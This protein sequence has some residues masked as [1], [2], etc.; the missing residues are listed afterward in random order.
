[1]VAMRDDNRYRAVSEALVFVS[2]SHEDRAFVP[3]LNQYLKPLLPSGVTLWW[4]NAIRVG[5]RFDDVIRERI[6]QS[7]AAVVLVSPALAASDFITN[8]EL[9]ALIERGIPLAPLH[10][11]AP[12]F[13][14]VPGLRDV[15]WVQP[16]VGRDEPI[17]L[18][19]D[20]ESSQAQIDQM[21]VRLSERIASRI[22]AEYETW[23]AAHGPDHEGPVGERAATPKAEIVAGSAGQLHGVPAL[24]DDIVDR[25]DELSEL[26]TLLLSLAPALGLTGT[27]TMG[28]QGQGGIGK[29]VLATALARDPQVLAAFP[30]GI[31]WV[32]LGEGT[33][34]GL[35]QQ[36]LLSL[37]D[38]TATPQN[39]WEIRQRLVEVLADKQTLLMV[40]DIWT[41]QAGR[42]FQL[43]G[44]R[45][46]V[47]YT[48][49]DERVLDDVG[50][51]IS[52]VDVLSGDAAWA[53]LQRSSRWADPERPAAWGRVAAATG[54]VALGLALAGAALRGAPAEKWSD[55]VAELESDVSWLDHP[56][57]DVF[58]VMNLATSQ[59]PGSHKQRLFSLAVYPE[60]IQIP[61]ESITT[62]WGHMFHDESKDVLALV[63]RL[64]AAELIERS[65]GHVR[66]HD[67]RREFLRLRADDIVVLH[68]RLIEA[69]RARGGDWA[70]IAEG[71]P[72]LADHLIAHLISALDQRQAEAVLRD[73]A[74]VGLRLVSKGPIA[75]DGDLRH[76]APSDTSRQLTETV[77]AEIG[78]WAHLVTSSPD[79]RLP[80]F[81]PERRSTVL[82]QMAPT[83]PLDAA[84][85]RRSVRPGIKPQWHLRAAHP[86]QRL[87]LDGHTGGVWGVAWSPDGTR[88]A[89]ASADKTVR[90]WDPATGTQTQQLDGHTDSVRGVA[91]SPDSTRLASASADKTV[92]IWPARVA[93]GWLRR[94]GP[95]R[96]LL[97][98]PHQSVNAGGVTDVSFAPDGIRLATVSG[99]GHVRLWDVA[100]LECLMSA[101]VARSAHGIDWSEA[102][103]AV[104]FET[105]VMVYEVLE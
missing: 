46:R 9:P 95:L 41:S 90:I 99:D 1:M 62:F 80:T 49:R 87:V 96:R 6:A 32:T 59:L 72:Y 51:T 93:Q 82:A 43:T 30:D 86:A 20:E 50:A 33:D 23:R 55:L 56:Y 39:P 71:D 8:V 79:E 66:L 42:E 11:R 40:D 4:D 38:P 18:T 102:G 105:T 22:R 34:M 85:L 19:G 53:I 91:W 101:R 89:S 3:K 81:S 74:W 14:A 37:V 83:A 17:M 69:Y 45:G 92:R 103:L 24:G 70:E 73:A 104:G 52:R 16:D 58:K 15:Q 36:E 13:D 97:R 76:L 64:A 26:R 68:S 31:F 2:Y 61:L 21:M 48:T 94:R 60:D 63:D 84:A 78:R 57:A 75:V 77:D 7:L 44:P 12:S 27:S 47:L 5:D 28:L 10:Y 88:L 29:T 100:S 65:T 98:V 35:K 54:G 67:L 25:P